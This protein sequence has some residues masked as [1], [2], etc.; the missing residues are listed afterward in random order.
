MFLG[1]KLFNIIVFKYLLKNGEPP[2]VFI[3]DLKNG[4]FM[5]FVGGGRFLA[6]TLLF[7]DKL[8]LGVYSGSWI[9]F[10][11][12]T[13]LSRILGGKKSCFLYLFCFSNCHSFFYDVFDFICLGAFFKRH[14][15]LFF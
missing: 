10:F 1:T 15:I 4:R 7:C 3:G 6:L 12:S 14:Y 9:V 8:G 13:Q 2:R 5:G 11:L